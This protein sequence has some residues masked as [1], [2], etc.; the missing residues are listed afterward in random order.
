M[1]NLGILG[2]KLFLIEVLVSFALDTKVFEQV[3][4]KEET[5]RVQ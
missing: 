5:R 3:V 4:F 2:A 1:E